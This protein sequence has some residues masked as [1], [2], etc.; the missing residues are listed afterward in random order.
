M[1]HAAQLINPLKMKEQLV[2]QLK[3][4]VQ[5]LER[6]ISF[7]QGNPMSSP[8][9]LPSR[10]LLWC[11]T[12]PGFTASKLAAFVLFLSTFS[13]AFCCSWRDDDLWLVLFRCFSAACHAYFHASCDIWCLP[14]CY[15]YLWIA[16][17][18]FRHCRSC[19]YVNRCLKLVSWRLYSYCFFYDLP[20]LADCMLL[21]ILLGT[22]FDYG[23][24]LWFLCDLLAV[25]LFLSLTHIVMVTVPVWNCADL[26]SS[27]LHFCD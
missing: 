12:S 24:L 4:Q 19:V 16:V 26:F 7:L 21:L 18:L 10:Q 3:T 22:P 25:D 27:R 13:F 15:R 8:C 20:P 9:D 1:L 6:F 23:L 5:D 17:L 2:N 14:L 11:C